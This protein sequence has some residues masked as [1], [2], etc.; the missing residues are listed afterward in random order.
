[1]YSYTT[2][3]HISIVPLTTISYIN[4]VHADTLL[5]MEENP[6]LII[7][8]TNITIIPALTTEHLI[9]HGNLM[10]SRW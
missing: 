3:H 6:F 1:M 9:I 4:K 7:E 10:E 5:E 8:H 2:P